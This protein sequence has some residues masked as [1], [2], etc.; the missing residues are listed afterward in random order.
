MNAFVFAT[1][2]LF[3]CASSP[4]RTSSRA[5]IGDPHGV[6]RFSVFMVTPEAGAPIRPWASAPVYLSTAAGLRLL[7]LTDIDGHFSIAK[8]QIW[9][10][11]A[12]AL[13]FCLKDSSE[14]SMLSVEKGLRQMD[15]YS[16]QI[17]IPTSV[18]E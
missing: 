5:V 13:F 1:L 4:E 12:R 2:L 8:D 11:G 7:G 16:I 18:I 6:I 17:P 10:R 14:C 15:E 9:V 3:G